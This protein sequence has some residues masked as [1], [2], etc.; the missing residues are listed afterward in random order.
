MRAISAHPARSSPW[1]NQVVEEDGGEGDDKSAEDQCCGL[2][3]ER[4]R[5]GVLE[6]VDSGTKEGQDEEGGQS[7]KSAHESSPN[8][9]GFGSALWRGA[10][11]GFE[12]H[13]SVLPR[14][15][16]GNCRLVHVEKVEIA[17]NRR[18]VVFLEDAAAGAAGILPLHLTVD[19][20]K[21]G[22]TTR[23]IDAMPALS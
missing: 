1:L 7:S 10:A 21:N 2:R 18:R 6:N 4:I 12:A 20:N 9:E 13:G 5:E 16:L 22:A 17:K 8:G 14:S 15:A 23:W 11:Q 19:F 3:G